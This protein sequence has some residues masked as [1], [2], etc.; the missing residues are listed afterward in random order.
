[1]G[2]PTRD[3]ASR[4]FD[5]K[6][7]GGFYTQDDVREIVAYAAERFVTVVPEI[8]MPGHAQ[9]AISAYPMLGNLGDSVG[10]WTMWGV[11]PYIFNPS[12]TTIAFLQDVLSE[13]LELF[14]G[15]YI[16][17]GGD[18]ATKVQWRNSPRAQARIRELGLKDENELQSWF[19]RQMDTFLT[20]RGRRMV[21]WDEILEGGLAPN[22]VVMSWRGIQ[23]GLAAA[24]DGHDV[25]MTP[26]AQTYFDHYQARPTAAEPLAIGGYLPIDSVYAYDPIPREL[27]PSLWKHV[28]GAQAQLWTEYMPVPKHVEY[29]AHPRMSALAETLWTPL[30]RKDFA[31]FMG[32]MPLQLKRLD[33]LDVNYRPFR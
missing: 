14:P 24:R 19:I 1:V 2:R 22:A 3:S 15:K 21:G 25:I 27:E 17:I 7:H 26:N 10:A 18:E 31:D 5:R 29:M 20:A 28:L 16:H 30:E 4:V 11:S 9:A 6:P 13:V 8:E 12:D 23:G 33:A 32:R